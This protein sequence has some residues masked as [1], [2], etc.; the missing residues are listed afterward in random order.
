MNNAITDKVAE[1]TIQITAIPTQ[2][3]RG[4]IHISKDFSLKN[5]LPLLKNKEWS[6]LN[7]ELKSTTAQ[8]PRATSPIKIIDPDHTKALPNALLPHKTRSNMQKIKAPTPQ[9]PKAILIFA[10]KDFT[11]SKCFKLFESSEYSSETAAKSD[12]S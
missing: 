9:I 4:Y 1:Q 12:P 5:Q 3:G 7:I 10:N 11:S 2:N 6:Q 8:T